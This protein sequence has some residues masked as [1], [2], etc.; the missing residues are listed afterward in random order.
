MMGNFLKCLVYTHSP[1]FQPESKGFRKRRTSEPESLLE[2]W[3]RLDVFR[4]H[5]ESMLS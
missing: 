2:G 5:E 3:D 4:P 1:V